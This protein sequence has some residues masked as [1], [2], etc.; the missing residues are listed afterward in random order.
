MARV[1]IVDD[2]RDL[3][4]SMSAGLT[5]GGHQ[6]ET[7]DCAAGALKAVQGKEPFDVVILDLGL[8]DRDGLQ[9]LSELRER[10]GGAP[11]IV[12]S[13]NSAMA[14]MVTAMRDGAF[15]YLSKPLRP[16]QLEQR[17]DHALRLASRAG[18]SQDRP[19]DMGPVDG[20]E[21]DVGAPTGIVGTS[22]S[23][24]EVFKMLGLLAASRTTVLIRGESG[25]GKELAARVLHRFAPD[26]RPEPFVAVSCAALP[27]ALVEGEIFGYRRGAFTGADRDHIGK[28]EA[29]EDG[30]LFLDEIGDV[31]LE[32]Q[33]KL[34]RVLQE[35]RYERLGETQSRPFLA[36]V[37][38]A[39]HCDLER[40]VR[41]GRFREDL[42][43]RLNVASIVLPPLRERRE[44]IPL[45]VAHLL[46]AISREVGR[47]VSVSVGAL[48]R[49]RRHDWPG[50]VRELRNVLTRATVTCRG[51]TL[52]ED[53]LE[54]CLAHADAEEQAAA[55]A[56]AA[57]VVKPAEPAGVPRFPT[58]DEVERDHVR[59]ALAFTNG[60]K[61]KA[62]TV[63]GIS[64]PTLLRKL[65]RYGLDAP[66]V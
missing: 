9:I 55:V 17:V 5:E 54:L 64:R 29:A 61:G 32:T 20:A 66:E 1:L 24:R 39:T 35:R 50:N 40:L 56:S 43:Y 36:R 14:S 37:V 12:V 23:M 22:S 38:A 33:V 45:L 59:R 31:P 53:D 27:A 44:D 8:P 26:S 28:L 30:T 47:R 25:T 2:E 21:D 46:D 65:K 19:S 51:N 18:S 10:C 11:V 49:L 7:V 3:R 42:Y 60:H 41:E 62:C 13:A 16:E 48:D 34:L 63:L 6:V 4:D 58:L 15:D 57:A 52:L